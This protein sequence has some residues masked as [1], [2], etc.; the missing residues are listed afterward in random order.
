MT[1]IQGNSNNN[2]YLQAGGLALAGGATAGA[3]EYFVR[4]QGPCVEND[5]PTDRF[6]R[7]VIDKLDSTEDEKVLKMIEE[8]S[9]FKQDIDKLTTTAEV[10]DYLLKQL[11]NLSSNDKKV[12]AEEIQNLELAEA[13]NFA[14]SHLDKPDKFNVRFANAISS[15]WDEKSKMFV[16]KDN[17]ISKEVF[18]V[19][20]QTAQK[21]RKNAALKE[22]GITVGIIAIIDGIYLACKSKKSNKE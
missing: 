20:E 17:K 5:L 15:C 9:T 3:M 2:A 6:V 18:D 22:A 16:N 7:K 14:K 11:D 1:T 8:C 19:I 10:E 13:K 21:A 12:L 4:K